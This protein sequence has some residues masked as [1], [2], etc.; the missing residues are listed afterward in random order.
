MKFDIWIEG[1]HT[2]EGLE[3]ARFIETVEAESFKEACEK[4][5]LNTIISDNDSPYKGYNLYDAKTCT[6]WSCKLF[7][8]EAD[9]RKG[10]G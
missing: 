5:K 2:M 3:E 1:Y 8:N 4:S 7:D 6:Y 10:Y 9:A